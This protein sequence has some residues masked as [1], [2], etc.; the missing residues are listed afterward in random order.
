MLAKLFI[1][2]Q[3]ASDNINNFEEGLQPFLLQLPNM[4]SLATEEAM[5]VDCH[6]AE[7]YNQLMAGSTV[8]GLQDIQTLLATAKIMLPTYG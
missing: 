1:M 6:E 7:D 8:T 4:S 3:L 2:L 5:N